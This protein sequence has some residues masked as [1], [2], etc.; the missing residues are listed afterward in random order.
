MSTPK[1]L[2]AKLL[3]TRPALDKNAPVACKARKVVFL[4][5]TEEIVTAWKDFQ[6]EANLLGQALE[7]AQSER[8]DG[9]YPDGID[10]DPSGCTVSFHSRSAARRAAQFLADI[11]GFWKGNRVGTERID[12]YHLGDKTIRCKI[13][14]VCFF[15]D[16]NGFMNFDFTYNRVDAVVPIDRDQHQLAKKYLD[17]FSQVTDHGV[18]S[19]WPYAKVDLDRIWKTHQLRVKLMRLIVSSCRV[20][21]PHPE[22]N[23][24]SQ[25][26]AFQ[27][28]KES[29]EILVDGKIPPNFTSAT[30]RA[31]L[32]LALQPDLNAIDTKKFCSEF[33]P[34]WATNKGIKNLPKK[35][36]QAMQALRGV[37]HGLHDD[38]L[39][40]RTA[41]VVGITFGKKPS[42]TKLKQ[43]IGFLLKPQED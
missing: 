4:H 35:F 37:I 9:L 31:V 39:G 11:E 30:K 10:H 20:K 24:P 19:D 16:P 23:A 25:A 2:L 41:R 13:V 8:S 1:Q 29:V 27:E 3:E 32:A 34:T 15:F 18:V 36:S 40:K 38:A 26:V 21:K 12:D 5:L 6:N 28:D 22:I 33:D 7:D 17:A 42:S 43:Q 14:H